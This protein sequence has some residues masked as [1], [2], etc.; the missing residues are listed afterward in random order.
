MNNVDAVV[1]VPVH[2]SVSDEHYLV[3]VAPVQEDAVV[4]HSTIGSDADSLEPFARVILLVV[5]VVAAASADHDCHTAAAAV[6]RGSSI[7]IH[8]E[9]VSANE[10]MRANA[11]A[12]VLVDV[13]PFSVL[14]VDAVVLR[15]DCVRKI[16]LAFL[17]RSYW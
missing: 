3:Y 16:V 15:Q 8:P 9:F 4:D 13:V 2:D 10:L 7:E 14:V 1:V 12:E 6:A 17:S 11:R 5:D